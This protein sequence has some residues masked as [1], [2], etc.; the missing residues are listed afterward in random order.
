MPPNPS[1][2]PGSP[3]LPETVREQHCRGIDHAVR[4]ADLGLGADRVEV[5]E[6]RLEHR[7]RHSL[8]RLVHPP[9]QLDLVVERAED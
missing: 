7:P 6:P 4:S 2:P 5:D 8:E 3:S 1:T 9:V